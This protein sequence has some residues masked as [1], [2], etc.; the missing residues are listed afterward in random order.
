M[1]KQVKINAT[2]KN[3]AAIIT[4]S[5]ATLRGS[6][7]AVNRATQKLETQ[8]VS[9]NEQLANAGAK[10]AD[11]KAGTASSAAVFALYKAAVEK[12]QSAADQRILAKGK[13]EARNEVVRNVSARMGAIGKALARR[14]DLASGKAKDKRTKAGKVAKTKTAA[15][16]DSQTGNV[17]TD[18]HVESGPVTEVKT[19]PVPRSIQHPVLIELINKL[20]AFDVGQQAV[21]AETDAVQNLLE[22]LT[23]TLKVNHKLKK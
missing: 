20:A 14:E 19:S 10:S 3:V 13:G 2:H 18:T 22:G 7:A 1:S 4:E 23:N 12:G 6:V 17:S 16:K 11:F 21:I 9:F 5:T 15:G 8:T